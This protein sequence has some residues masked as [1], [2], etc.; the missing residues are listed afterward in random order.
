V[1]GLLKRLE[2]GYE[3]EGVTALKALL[4]GFGKKPFGL[5]PIP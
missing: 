5:F 4:G 3:L 1:V 2:G